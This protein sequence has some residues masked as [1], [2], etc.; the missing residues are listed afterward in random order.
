MSKANV[1]RDRREAGRLLSEQLSGYASENPVIFGLPRGGVV[2]AYEIALTL[3]A[4]LEIM[5]ACKLGAP[6][7]SELGIGAVAP[8]GITVLDEAAVSAL[9]ISEEQVGNVAARE[10]AEVNRRLRNYRGESDLPDLEGRTAIL[11]DD[12]LATGVTA[13]AAIRALRGMNPAKI[14]L[15]VGV[16]AR[17]SAHVIENEVDELV[18]VSM[19]AHFEAVGM[20]YERF[21]QNTDDEILA[22]LRKARERSGVA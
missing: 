17:E 14:V 3:D 16:C 22:L 15:A 1:L 19:P 20:W 21:E 5:V 9:G 10:R 4:P 6:G 12:G 18:C 13:L 7:Q 11:V 2:V 8:G